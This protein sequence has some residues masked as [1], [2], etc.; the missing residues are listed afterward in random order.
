MKAFYIYKRFSVRSTSSQRPCV[1]LHISTCYSPRYQDAGNL[2]GKGLSHFSAAHISDAVQGQ[3][4]EGGVA[5]REVVL[6]AIIDQPN[7]ITVWVHQHGDKQ[8]ALKGMVNS[9]GNTPSGKYIW[10][11]D[12]QWTYNLFLCVLVGTEEVDSL[13]VSKVDIV[14]Q[15]KDKEKLAHIFLF[16]VAIQSLVTCPCKKKGDWVSE[17]CYTPW[18]R[19]LHCTQMSLH[20]SASLDSHFPRGRRHPWIANS[21][22]HVPTP[23]V[24]MAKMP[25]WSAN[26][27]RNSMVLESAGKNNNSNNLCT[28]QE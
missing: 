27:F 15:K 20:P 28:D 2:R 12:W 6:D 4:H 19:S 10:I 9:S 25:S 7:Q 3:V 21:F 24:C 18:D 17:G 26:L 1:I 22:I 23:Y 14:A 16:A 8:V 13:H 11:K 5:A